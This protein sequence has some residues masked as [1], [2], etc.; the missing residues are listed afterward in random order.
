MT[1]SHA[2]DR[3]LHSASRTTVAML[4][5]RQ[6]AAEFTWLSKFTW[7]QN[8]LHDD[9]GYPATLA[10]HRLAPP[11]GGSASVV[12]LHRRYVTAA[13]RAVPLGKR[14]SSELFGSCLRLGVRGRTAH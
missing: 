5:S 9:L 6:W 10:G 12:G 4:P 1:I 14:G 8:L 3:N 2:D 11:V 13:E 7:L